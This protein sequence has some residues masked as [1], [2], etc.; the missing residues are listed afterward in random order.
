MQKTSST[1]PETMR[2]DGRSHLR[3]VVV[4]GILGGLVLLTGG[5]A[6]AQ[7]STAPTEDAITA[8]KEI[9]ETG[10]DGFGCADCHGVDQTLMVGPNLDN[11]DAEQIHAALLGIAEMGS[12]SLSDEEVAAV[13]AYLRSGKPEAPAGAGTPEDPLVASGRAIFESTEG[14]VACKDCHGAD[15]TGIVAPDIQGQSLSE[16]HARLAGIKDA[17]IMDFTDDQLRAVAAYLES[18]NKN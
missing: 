4:A 16:M 14:R 1:A 18:L 10:F 12:F 17:T 8:G 13:M 9:F 3:R 11:P 6:A 5:P 7:T 15:P 2:P